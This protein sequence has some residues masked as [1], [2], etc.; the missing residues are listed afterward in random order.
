MR[1]NR[2]HTP[3]TGL[4]RPGYFDVTFFL[5]LPQDP[6]E[7]APVLEAVLPSRRAR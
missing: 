7:R 6:S 2:P 3:D 5:S 4:E 1:K